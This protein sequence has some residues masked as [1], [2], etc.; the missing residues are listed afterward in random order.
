MASHDNFIDLYHVA[1]SVARGAECV[2][3]HLAAKA[4]DKSN[5]Y[6]LYA[7]CRGHSSYITGID[8][9]C[10]CGGGC[11]GSCFV[12]LLTLISQL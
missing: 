12:A 2:R 3:V 8:F 11:G 10:G 4:L 9:R 7:T 6:K 1:R 5:R